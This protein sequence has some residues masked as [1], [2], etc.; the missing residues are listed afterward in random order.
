MALTTY[1]PTPPIFS[2]YFKRVIFQS[3]YHHDIRICFGSVL[4]AVIFNVL[5]MTFY[6]H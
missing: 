6:L 3:Q 1:L 2:F 5:R 4:C